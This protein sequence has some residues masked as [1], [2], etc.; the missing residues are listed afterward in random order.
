MTGPSMLK[1]Y[2]PPETDDLYMGRLLTMESK[3]EAA[4]L[5]AAVCNNIWSRNDAGEVD[6][7]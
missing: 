6:L 3:P 5:Q 4:R 2:S 7:V 1:P